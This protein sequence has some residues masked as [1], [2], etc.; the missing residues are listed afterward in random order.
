MKKIVCAMLAALM[1]LSCALA[2]AEAV[3]SK[4]VTDITTVTSWTENDP[5]KA[6]I[7][8]VEPSEKVKEYIDGAV[9][10]I[11]SGAKKPVELFTEETR[12]AIAE[13]VSDPDS[14]EINEMIPIDVIN[15]TLEDGYVTAIFTTITPYSPEQ[16]LVGV[17]SFLNGDEVQEMVLEAKANEDGT[18]TVKFPVEVMAEFL[19]AE[20]TV[21][22]LLN[23]K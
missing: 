20:N 10:A 1:A 2:L 23:T 15:Y 5:D 12:A 14:L 8:V 9:E 11:D 17:I 13:V 22:T 4:T 16:T 3:P 7:I 19:K 18:V 6:V 21:L